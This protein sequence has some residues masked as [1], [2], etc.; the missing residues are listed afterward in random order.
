MH[1]TKAGCLG[2]CAVANVANLVFDGRSIWFHSVNTPWH[3]QLIFD[4]VEMMIRANGFL[5]APSELASYTFNFYD[6]D[7]RG[8]R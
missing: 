1:L 7:A 3:V 8:N 2:P 5:P 4:Y 6:W